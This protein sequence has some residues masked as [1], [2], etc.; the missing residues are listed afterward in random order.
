MEYLSRV[1]LVAQGFQGFRF[2][3]LC[4]KFQLSHLF[5]ADDLLMFCYGDLSSATLLLRAFLSFSEASGLRMNVQ[6]S[7]LYANGV[8]AQVLQHIC[9]AAGM[10]LASLPFSYLGVPITA[11]KLSVLECFVLVEKYVLATLHND[12]ARIFILPKSII[13][14]IEDTCRNF[15][16]RGSHIYISSPPVAWDHVCKEP[17][18][19]GLGIRKAYEWNI[20]S[21]EKYIWWIASKKDHLWVKW[22]NGIYL[23]GK[24]WRD[25]KCNVSSTWSWRRMCHVKEALM[26]GYMG[27]WWLKVGNEYSVQHGYQWLNCGGTIV[28]WGQF[29]WNRLGLPRQRFI[30]WMVMHQRLYTKARLARFGVGNDSLC[31]LCAD[32]VETQVHLFFECIYSRKCI[33]IFLAKLGH[34]DGV[35]KLPEVIVDKMGREIQCRCRAVVSEHVLA[36][37]DEWVIHLGC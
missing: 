14:R 7:C 13:K 5:F 9:S 10:K 6:K 35:L 8:P 3:S 21:V 17:E 36:K 26:D 31:C 34:F 32:A 27:D 1:L 20:A 16:W 24:D 11:R 25:M 30:A 19:G 2:H 22:I 29:V 12:W 28:P 23:R 18:M 15:L 33:Q 4:R 37:Y